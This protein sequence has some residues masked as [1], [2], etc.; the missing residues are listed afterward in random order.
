MNPE[1]P[2]YIVSKGRWESRLTSKAFESMKVP[3]HIVIEPQEYKQYASV[4]DAKKI[5]ILPHKYLQDYDTFDNLGDSK[6][7]RTVAARNFC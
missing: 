5:L 6:C 4:I 3:Y 1:Y 2:V 7:N